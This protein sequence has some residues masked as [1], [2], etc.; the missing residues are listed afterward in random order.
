MKNNLPIASTEVMLG[1]DERIIPITSLSDIR[2]AA[3]RSLRVEN[4]NDTSRVLGA[5][6]KQSE[7]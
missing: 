7:S 2:P 4:T 1:G 3:R 6:I 5:L